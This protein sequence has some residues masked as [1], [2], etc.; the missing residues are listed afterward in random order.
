M[1]DGRLRQPLPLSL[2]DLLVAV[3]VGHVK[4]RPDQLCKVGALQRLQLP[5]GRP[6]VPGLQQLAGIQSSLLEEV[7]LD[8]LRLEVLAKCDG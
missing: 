6:E 4:G 1:H 8:L 3:H 5:P 2:A 7:P